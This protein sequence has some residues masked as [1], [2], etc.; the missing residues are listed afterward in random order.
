LGLG[1]IPRLSIK[2]HGETR[3]KVFVKPETKAV[4][5]YVVCAIL[6][7]INFDVQSYNSFIDLQDKLHQNICRKR[8]LGSMGT[9]DYDKIKGPITYEAVAPEEIVF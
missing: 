1:P 5:P 6:R 8:T 3:E 7:N 2:N 4:R 9:H